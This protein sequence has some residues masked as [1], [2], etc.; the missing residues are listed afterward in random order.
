MSDNGEPTPVVPAG[1]LAPVL[2]TEITVAEEG[3]PDMASPRV[4]QIRQ[5][6]QAHLNI[7][8]VAEFGL[9]AA[10]GAGAW[11]AG[12]DMFI[13]LPGLVF[14]L[15]F[16][17]AG[18]LASNLR[19]TFAVGWIILFALLFSGEGAI[20]HWHSG[21]L[22]TQESAQTAPPT[23]SAPP[24]PATEYALLNNEELRRIAYEMSQDV[25]DFYHVY[26]DRAAEIRRNEL[27]S[28]A[29]K[30]DQYESLDN[31]VSQKFKEKF[32]SKYTALQAEMERR[33]SDNMYHQ[34]FGQG[35]IDLDSLPYLAEV[36]KREAKKLP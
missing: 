16:A 7:I 9:A 13:V 2:Q 27:L 4:G 17:S 6:I 19:T 11:Y 28:S 3:K 31:D 30:G 15:A 14:A 35:M 21:W 26:N 20:L 24:A 33:I 8:R 1:P 25:G 32:A 18:I 5:F 12:G 22:G 23:P 29:E 36:L 10:F 34:S